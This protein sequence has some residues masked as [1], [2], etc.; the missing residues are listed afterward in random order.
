MSFVSSITPP[1]EKTDPAWWFVFQNDRLMIKQEE[2]QTTLPLAVNLDALNLNPVREQYLGTLQ[3]IHCYSAEL[4]PEAQ[5]P[6]NTNFMNLRR[7]FG[8]LEEETLKAAIYAIQIVKWDQ[9]HQ[10]CGR[11]NSAMDYKPDERA[12]VCPHCGL[13]NFPQLVPAIMAAVIKENKILLANGENFPPDFF[14]VLAGFVEPGETLEECVKREVNEEVGLEVKN[15]TYFSSQPWPFPNSL[16]IAFTMD[17]AAGNIVVDGSEI[18]KADWFDINSLPPRPSAKISLA[19]R[20]ID[21]FEQN[22]R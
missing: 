11:C 2:N 13:I 14:S 18:K 6:E 3:G 12:K 1:S 20:L 21:W 8:Q 10:Y 16:M 7:L 15:I 5:C 9:T 22:N 17:Y 19:G 4:T